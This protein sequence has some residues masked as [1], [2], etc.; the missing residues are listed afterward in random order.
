MPLIWKLT[1]YA[2]ALL[3][4]VTALVVRRRPTPW[5]AAYLFACVPASIVWVNEMWMTSRWI[6][7]AL[8]ALQLMAVV[9]TIC[10][11]HRNCWNPRRRYLF[12]G[13]CGLCAIGGTFAAAEYPGY[14]KALWW[15]QL[16]LEVAMTAALAA[17]LTLFRWWE[18]FRPAGWTIGNVA[19]FEVYC[20]V[21]V[22]ALLWPIDANNW[23]SV[24]LTLALIQDCCLLWWCVL[25][26]RHL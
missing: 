7:P 1:I 23:L 24:D 12:A 15:V 26:T 9:E 19:V 4:F 2:S 21:E 17:S 20:A 13:F 22:I 5:L 14:P 10:L 11:M 18:D 6:R 16:W 3:F 8:L 25:Y